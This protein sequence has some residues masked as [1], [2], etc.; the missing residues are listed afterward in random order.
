MKI[1]DISI[2]RPVFATMMIAALLVVGIFSYYS[3]SIEMFP[4]VDMPIVIVQTIYP[5]A[6]A[7]SIETEITKNIEEV[8]NEISGVKSISSTSNEGYALIVVEFNL[9]IDG[10]LA[11]QDVREKVASIRGDLPDDMEEPVITQFDFDAQPI[12]S[13]ALTGNRSLRDITEIAKNDIKTRLETIPGVGNVEIVGGYDREIHIGLNP[14]QME[15]HLVTVNDV[16]LAVQAANME[17]PG[18]RIDESDREYLVRIKGR[19]ERV[20]QFD[21]IIVKNINGN[22]VYLSDIAVVADTIAEQRSLSRY[23]G[24]AAVGLNII[25]QSGT[26]IV[27]MAR[28]AKD[29]VASLKK[30]L[31]PDITVEIVDDQSLFIE[32]S[33]HEIL[34]NIR[35]GTILA[36][37]VIFLFLLDFRPTLITGLS[38]PISIIATFT[39]M[40][41]LGFTI[42]FMTLLGL[43]LAVGIL[44]DDAIVVVE[45]IYRHLDMGKSPMQAAFDGTKEIGLAVMATT[46]T[47]MV[48]FIPVAFMEGIIGRFFYQFGITVAFAVFISLFVAFTLTPML[49]SRMLKKS[50][51]ND[52]DTII[53]SKHHFLRPIYRVLGLWNRMFDAILPAYKNLLSFSLKFRWLVIL[54]AVFIFMGSMFLAGNLGQ[55]WFEEADQNKVYI[56]LE[57]PPGTNLW[58]TSDRIAEVEKVVQ[59]FPEVTNVFVT[60][61]SGNSSVRDG[62]VVLQL[63]DATVREIPAKR[64]T[65]SIRTMLNIIPGI[66]YS[67]YMTPPEGGSSKPIELSV[68][69][70]DRE[71]LAVITKKVQQIA[72]NIPGTI[73]VDNSMEEGQPEIQIE[74][75]RKK[76]DDLGLSLS[77]I[78]LTLRTF[79]EGDVVTRFKEGDEEYDVRVQLDEKYRSVADDL[80]S[81]LVESDKKITGQ[82]EFLVSLGK[83]GKINKGTAI[84]KY[85][86]YNRQNEIRVNSNVLEGYFSGTIAQEILTK[87]GEIQLPPGYSISAVGQEEIRN[88]SNINILK[89]LIL[90]I[91]FIYLLLASQY[92]SFFDPFSIM[93][94][95]PMSLIGA[96]LGLLLFNSSLSIMA[97]I[98]IVMLMGLVT[99]NAILLIDFVKQQREKGV[100][101]FEAVMIA[102]P[103]RL[104]PILMTT[105]AT[106]FGMLPLALGWGPGAEMRAPMARA[107]IGG[108]ISSTLLTLV[109][110]PVVYTVINDAVD[111]IRRLFGKKSEQASLEGKIIDEQFDSTS[112]STRIQSDI[113]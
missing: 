90:A 98:G 65:D 104:R 86:R 3:M 62:N 113:S 13:L 47:I 37:I 88:E 26:N 21:D 22:P 14:R 59:A 102:G 54:I 29:V 44:I 32:D 1:S 25:K 103:I 24:Q 93:L 10:A 77:M 12:L 99:K 5:G 105:F 34:F 40:N 85:L 36:I 31:P 80:E 7:E 110:V 28:E 71:E 16:Q 63:T 30:E 45:N 75:D 55:E 74:I 78:P 46:L 73:D 53:N 84:G 81:I 82:E 91:I 23:D 92:E 79:V 95:L 106:V 6:S 56:T 18:G 87:A 67:V 41:F 76:A 8:V 69:G 17:I 108:I 70:N 60:I 35:F 101:M 39:L 51:G 48:V 11:A 38:I 111:F 50:H 61:G 2:R 96:I 9:E 107:A 19:L 72:R 64:M 94:S 112:E 89:A 42:N 15:A 52:L 66:K 97:M 57:T 33:I 83:V 20:S 4:N 27:D 49:S 109:V 100:S 58:E 43:S 68:R